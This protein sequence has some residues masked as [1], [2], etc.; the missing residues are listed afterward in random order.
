LTTWRGGDGSLVNVSVVCVNHCH[1]IAIGDQ[2]LDRVVDL[3]KI[4]GVEES[5]DNFLLSVGK[6][7]GVLVDREDDTDS[8]VSESVESLL[9]KMDCVHLEV[10]SSVVNSML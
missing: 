4:N 5:I 10:K 8:S 3:S 2:R 1:Q 7:G 9:S 6:F